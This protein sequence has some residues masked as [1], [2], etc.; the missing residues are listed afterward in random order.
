MK[1]DSNQNF[2]FDR[3]FDC[4]FDENSPNFETLDCFLKTFQTCR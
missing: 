2:K 1:H 4:N 3:M